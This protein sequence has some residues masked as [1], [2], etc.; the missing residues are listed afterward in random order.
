MLTALVVAARLELDPRW[1]RQ[2]NR[3]L[4]F[5]PTV[6]LAAWLGGFGP[7]LLSTILST[8]ALAYFWADP[9]HGFHAA[10]HRSRSLHRGERH[11]LRW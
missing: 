3:H 1:G 4:V 11:G 2:H 10:P 9:A 6:L 8:A 5:L 7:G